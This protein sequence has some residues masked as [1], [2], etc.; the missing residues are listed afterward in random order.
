MTLFEFFDSAPN[1][2]QTGSDDN[3]VLKKDA[4]RKTR[5]TIEQINRLRVMNDIRRLEYEKSIEKI[6]KQYAPAAQPAGGLM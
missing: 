6:S 4:R 1:G 5:L 2:Y 3:S